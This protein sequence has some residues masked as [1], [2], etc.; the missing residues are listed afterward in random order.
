MNPQEARL[1]LQ[2]RRARG[3]DDSLPAMAEARQTIENLPDLKKE[4]EEDAAFDAL[5]GEKLRSI[6]VPSTLRSSI[7]AGARITPQIPWWRRRLTVF[8]AAALLAV[9]VSSLLVKPQLFPSGHEIASSQANTGLTEFREATTK[10]VNHDGI[11]FSKASEDFS[12]LKTYLA[13]HSASSPDQVSHA[14]SPLPTHGCEIFQWKGH[15]VTLVC[16]ETKD[17]GTVHLFTINASD[18]PADLSAPLLASANGWE[19]ITWK[20]NGKIMQLIG[21]TTPERLKQLALPG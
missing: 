18:L 20:Q 21:Q 19:T 4:L 10:K 2:C 17:A 14:L 13:S 9:G 5:I 15:E 7:L 3:Q 12:E 1:I 11:H 8:S 16:F 6:V